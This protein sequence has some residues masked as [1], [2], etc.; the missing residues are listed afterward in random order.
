[1][2]F[3]KFLIFLLAMF[4]VS[5]MGFLLNRQ[6]NEESI[7]SLIA[8]ENITNPINSGSS[9]SA[10]IYIQEIIKETGY[11]LPLFYLGLNTLARY[12]SEQSSWRNWVPSIQWHGIKNQYHQWLFGNGE[13][14]KG[15]IRG[16]FGKSLRDGSLVSI[17]LLPKI[18]W[19]I[20][21]GVLAMLIACLAAIPSGIIAG[22]KA[23]G[24]FDHASG[25]LFLILYAMPPFFL[26]VLLLTFFSNPDYLDWFPSSG[27]MDPAVFNPQWTWPEKLK[28]HI[29]Y[30]VLPVL[31]YAAIFFAYISRQ[32]RDGIWEQMQMGYIRTARAKGLSEWQVLYRHAFRNT[33]IPMITIFSGLIPVALGG[34]IIIEN[35]FSIP[36]IGHEIYESIV[37]RDHPVTIALFLF[38]GTLTIGFYLLADVLYWIADPRLRIQSGNS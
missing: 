21:L 9:S 38:Y 25:I 10:E 37:G 28:H 16:D 12:K 35:I 20:W 31:T 1:M 26:G 13:K 36:G 6:P 15:I 29:P 8:S 23:G 34:S 4:A 33:I 24:F 5:L 19:S 3:K 22:Y 7:K 14:R 11:D 30:L 32:I 2:L 27:I 18:K 17:K